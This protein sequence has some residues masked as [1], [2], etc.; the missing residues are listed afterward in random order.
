MIAIL[1]TTLLITVPPNVELQT[2]NGQTVV[3]PIVAISTDRIGVD[4]PG[5][6]TEYRTDELV[7]LQVKEPASAPSPSPAVWVEL[8]DGSSLVGQGFT[9]R[10]DRAELR[11][12]SQALELSRKDLAAVRFQRPSDALAAEWTRI[13]ETKTAGDLL[14]IRK[15]D[16]LDYHKGVIGDVTDSEV[17]FELDGDRLPVKRAKIAGLVYYQA[18]G[19]SLPDGTCRIT[20][21]EGSCWTARTLALADKLEWTTPAGVRMSR[22]LAEV[23]R[24]DFASDKVVFLSDL[25]PESSQWTPFFE[26]EKNLPAL[27]QFFAPRTDRNLRGS[28]LQLDGRQ[29]DKGLA[30]HTRTKLVYRLPDR[31][32]RLKATAG[33]DDLFRPNGVVRLVIQG[34]ERVLMEATITGEEPPLAIDVDLSGVRR[35]TILA[36]FGAGLDVGGHLLLCEARVIK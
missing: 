9:A 13:V 22:T 17:Q 30:L 26:L 14:V 6:R 28:R 29:Y 10:G 15:G 31:F 33:I 3:G 7:A 11:L 16:S 34:D 23:R 32:R 25:Q 20:D 19:R 8:V 4:A 36:D 24:I 1:L 18:P 5:G 21:V 2:L 35:L 12:G 27:S